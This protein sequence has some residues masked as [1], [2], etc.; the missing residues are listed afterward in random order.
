MRENC[1]RRNNGCLR[2][3][4]KNN[5]E[6]KVCRAVRRP[7]GTTRRPILIECTDHFIRFVPEDVQLTPAELNG[8][9]SGFNPL[10]IAARELI[11]Y[12]KA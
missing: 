8:F 12:W 6:E 2:Q 10:L 3:R 4:T 5:R 1:S 7:H 11:H 9:T